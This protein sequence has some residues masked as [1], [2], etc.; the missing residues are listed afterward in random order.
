[1]MTRAEH[2]RAAG[3]LPGMTLAEIFFSWALYNAKL[4]QRPDRLRE[5]GSVVRDEMNAIQAGLCKQ[6]RPSRG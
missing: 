5:A 4:R 1:M 3:I 2:E 6:A